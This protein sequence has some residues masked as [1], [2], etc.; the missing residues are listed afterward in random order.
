MVA[1]TILAGAG[2]VAALVPI[3]H[4]F[5]HTPSRL[6][7]R[8]ALVVSIIKGAVTFDRVLWGSGGGSRALVGVGVF[9]LI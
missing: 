4:V 3:V 7:T 8:T 5:A 6:W 1:S 9:G 2:L